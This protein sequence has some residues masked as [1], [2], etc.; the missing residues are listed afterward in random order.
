[1]G[2]LRDAVFRRLAIKVYCILGFVSFFSTPEF[3]ATKLASKKFAKALS[4]A[5]IKCNDIKPDAKQRTRQTPLGGCLGRLKEDCGLG[6]V[7]LTQESNVPSSHAQVLPGRPVQ[8]IR[9]VTNDTR[10]KSRTRTS[11]I[12]ED[13]LLLWQLCVIIRNSVKTGQKSPYPCT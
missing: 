2:Y 12:S 3:K 9:S 6:R 5:V 7:S 8:E 11:Q 1:M 13:P 4:E 10:S